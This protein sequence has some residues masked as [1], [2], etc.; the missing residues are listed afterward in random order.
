[1]NSLQIGFY[2]SMKK[3][4]T[5]DDLFIL[6]EMRLNRGTKAG[7]VVDSSKTKALAHISSCIGKC[8]SAGRSTLFKWLSEDTSAGF[9][10]Y[11]YICCYVYS[12]TFE[13]FSYVGTCSQLELI[14]PEMYIEPMCFEW[15]NEIVSDIGKCLNQV[16]YM[17]F[18]VRRWPPGTD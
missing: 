8:L 14:H 6:L 16:F 7:F 5:A 18:V 13:E 15:E 11:S 3:K 9:L 17:Q 12:G 10:L 1:M 4:N 2:K